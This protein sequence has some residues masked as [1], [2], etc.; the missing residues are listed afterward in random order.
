MKN[1]GSASA[2][3]CLKMKQD[4]DHQRVAEAA[5]LSQFCEVLTTLRGSPPSF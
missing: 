1:H 2:I 4:L 5:Y 3:G